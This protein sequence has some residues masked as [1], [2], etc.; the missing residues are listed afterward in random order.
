MKP[1]QIGIAA[2]L[3]LTMLG[4]AHADDERPLVDAR[5]LTDPD[6][7]IIDS[8]EVEEISEAEFAPSARES[9]HDPLIDVPE[10]ITVAWDIVRDLRN[11]NLILDVVFN[12]GKKIWDIVEANKPVVDIETDFATALPKGTKDWR[13]FEGWQSPAAR[14]YRVR[15]KNRFGMKVVDFSYRVLYTYGGSVLGRGRYLTNVTVE[16]D[17]D[18]LWGYKFNAKVAIREPINTGTTENPVA[19]LEMAMSWEVDTVVKHLEGSTSYFV[20]GD[21]RFENLTHGR[22]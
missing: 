9:S 15:Y 10:T 5:L 22:Q 16:P 1:Y 18:V 14:V 20:R 3:A 11:G 21:G 12:M 17:V 6:Y 2:V 19:G 7:F 4:A 8:V 13:A